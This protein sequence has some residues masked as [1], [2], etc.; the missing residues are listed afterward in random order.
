MALNPYFL[1]GSAGEQYLMQDLIN[2]QLKIYGIDVYYMP[3]KILGRETFSNEVIMS[4]FD[5]N[6]IIEAYLNN[7]EGY[8]ENTDIFSKFG[9]ET[10]DEVSLTISRERWETF[11]EP[12]LEGLQANDADETILTSRPREGDIIFF[13]LG[14]RMF[15]IKYVEHENPFYQLGKNYV[16]ELKCE[17]LQLSDSEIIETSVEQIDDSVEDEGYITTVSLAGIGSTAV[18]TATTVSGGVQ[19]ITIVNDG[20]EYSSAPTVSISTAPSGGVD[21]LA[22]A[23]VN[24]GGGISTVYITNPGAGYT[25]APTVTF[26]GGGGNG[27]V[28][29]ATIADG[30]ITIAISTAGSNYYTDPT[31]T[32]DISPTGIGSTATPIF[33]V[34]TGVGGTVIGVNFVNAGAGYTADPNITFSSP[35]IGIGTFQK[36]ETVTG[37]LSGTTAKVKKYDE[38]DLF[39]EVYINSGNFTVGEAI[40]GSASS[41][42]RIVASYNNEPS[43]EIEFSQNLEIEEFADDLLDFTEIN[44]FGTF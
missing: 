31:I 14:E 44:P 5:D 16:Y 6:F 30:A 11:I 18:G 36:N 27:R 29:T 41:A 37:S 13:P 10:K 2:E 24:S 43:Q 22:F 19:F 42:S 15:E 26:S 20:Y 39:L 8:G 12:F 9:I 32:F 34:V 4:K 1:Q 38:N 40:V 33:D 21:A 17:L 35:T 7:V 25:E 3:R 28:A 23:T